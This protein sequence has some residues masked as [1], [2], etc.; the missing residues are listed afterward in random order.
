MIQLRIPTT[1]NGSLIGGQITLKRKKFREDIEILFNKDEE[2]DKW[3]YEG[4]KIANQELKEKHLLAKV[5]QYV[6]QKVVTKESSEEQ[7]VKNWLTAL[8][9]MLD[10]SWL[11][12]LRMHSENFALRKELRS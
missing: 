5:I 6:K 11:K 8:S 2:S 9:K 4:I 3:N 12:A 1:Y 10:K 7:I